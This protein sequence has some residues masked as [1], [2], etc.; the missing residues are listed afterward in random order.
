V[1]ISDS[2]SRILVCGM[3]VLRKVGR[4]A[5]AAATAAVPS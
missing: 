3:A 4:V 5:A 1:G 2:S